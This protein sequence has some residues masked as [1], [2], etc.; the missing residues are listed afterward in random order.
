MT[1]GFVANVLVNMPADKIHYVKLCSDQQVCNG[2]LLDCAGFR[3]FA[4]GYGHHPSNVMC[5]GGNTR[6]T[7]PPVTT[8]LANHSLPT[9]T[10]VSWLATVT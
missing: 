8:A 4:E 2:V 6:L 9:A 3:H 10:P 1:S 7:K 5:C